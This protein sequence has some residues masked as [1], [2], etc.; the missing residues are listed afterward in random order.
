M[1]RLP[2]F[3]FLTPATPRDAALLLRD[4]G[5]AMLVA[6]GTDLLRAAPICSRR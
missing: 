1:L 2:R 3:D 4:A 5:T 6:G